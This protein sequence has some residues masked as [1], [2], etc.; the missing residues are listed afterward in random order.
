LFVQEVDYLEKA[1]EAWD[2][3]WEILHIDDGW[4]KDAGSSLET[5]IV[6]SRHL[7][8]IGKLFKLEV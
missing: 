5:G 1:Q 2:K 3:A 8:H 6:Y 7:K 4:K